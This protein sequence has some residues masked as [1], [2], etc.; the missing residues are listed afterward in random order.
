MKACQD[1]FLKKIYVCGVFLFKT[2]KT[3]SEFKVNTNIKFDYTRWFF[4][5]GQEDLREDDLP[6]LNGSETIPLLD[7]SR[8]QKF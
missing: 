8:V 2:Q 5:I 3:F 7:Y 4:A 6:V 1:F